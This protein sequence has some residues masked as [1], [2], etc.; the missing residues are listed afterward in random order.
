ME[1]EDLSAIVVRDRRQRH[2]FS[3]HNRVIDE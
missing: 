3:V 1:T 2:Q